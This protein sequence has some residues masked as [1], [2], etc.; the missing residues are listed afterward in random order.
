[1]KVF[2]TKTLADAVALLKTNKVSAIIYDAPSLLRCADKDPSLTVAPFS[3]RT[4]NYG[5]VIPM[6]SPWRTKINRALLE[7][8]ESGEYQRIY[9]K[10]F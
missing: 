5:F 10:W 8:Q 1:M 7:L 6:N 9:D 3:I 2:K 4:Q